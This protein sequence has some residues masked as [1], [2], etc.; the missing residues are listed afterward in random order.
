MNNNNPP[1]FAGNKALRLLVAMPALNEERTVG[2]IVRRIPRNIPG[3]A[4]VETLVIDDGSVDQTADEAIRA[5]ARVVRHASPRGVGAA[6]HSAL[7]YALNMPADILVTIDSDGQFD[8]ESIPSIVEP[9]V[10]ALNHIPNRESVL[11]ECSRLLVSDGGRLIITMIPPFISSVWHH[12]R[13]P[14]DLDQKER[15]MKPGEVYGMTLARINALCEQ[16]GFV[17]A[18]SEKFMLGINSLYVFNKRG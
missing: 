14:W 7:A 12:L 2:D 3:I 17:L 5:G 13:F 4:G 1:A 16:A 15:G 9:I 8:P 18:H 6:F 10:A 11:K